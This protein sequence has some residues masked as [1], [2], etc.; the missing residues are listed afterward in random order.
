MGST[1]RAVRAPIFLLSLFSALVLTNHNF[2][3]RSAEANRGTGSD[4]AKRVLI[5]HSFGNAA[6]PFT[7][8]SHA[9]ETEL[10]REPGLR[11]DLDEVSL[12]VARYATL[13]MEEA[14]VEFMGKRQIRW[15]PDLVVTVGSPAGVFVAHHRARLF[16]EATPIIYMGMDQRRLPGSALEKNATFV[17]ESFDLPGLVEDILQ[18]GYAVDSCGF[19][20]LSLALSCLSRIGPRSMAWF[21]KR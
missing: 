16:P 15:Q 20:S 12:N 11:V 21:S 2:P 18:S 9:F 7:T 3:A 10:T 5:V 6:P 1:H 14:F 17:G 8:H 4:Q 19:W 13:D